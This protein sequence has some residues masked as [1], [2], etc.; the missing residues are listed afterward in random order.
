MDYKTIALECAAI[1]VS[2][3]VLILPVSFATDVNI[4]F[5]SSTKTVALNQETLVQKRIGSP[6][7]SGNVT[8]SI[9]GPVEKAYVYKCRDKNPANCDISNSDS[10]SGAFEKTYKFA[11]ISANSIANMLILVKAAASGTTTWLGFWEPL[12]IFSSQVY[13]T[14]SYA[15]S[16]DFYSRTPNLDFVSDFITNYQSIPFNTSS[17]AESVS[18]GASKLFVLKANKEVMESGG[19]E[20]GRASC[21]ERV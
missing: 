6:S 15:D 5:G 21:R 12:K 14:G 18:L 2:Y 4:I 10:F 13:S 1:L 8:V 16:A 19:F 9:T 17:T 11:D 3:I 7:G 20:I